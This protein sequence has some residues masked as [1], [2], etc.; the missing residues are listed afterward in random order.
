MSDNRRYSKIIRVTP[1]VDTQLR[2]TAERLGITPN[3]A[4]C[5][6]LTGAAPPVTAPDDSKRIAPERLT[7]ALDK[8]VIDLSISR[9]EEYAVT[10]E[11]V[12]RTGLN[13]I[14]A[15]RRDLEKRR[16]SE[17]SASAS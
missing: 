3:E 11:Y 2:A 15:V 4:A 9:K 13:R 1:E 8:R 6:L 5:K 14:E 17:A 7:E 10:L 12:V 16:A